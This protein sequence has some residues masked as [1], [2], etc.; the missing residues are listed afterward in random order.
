MLCQLQT[1]VVIVLTHGEKEL[2]VLVAEDL[3][4]QGTLLIY[5]MA[6]VS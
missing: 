2:R 4:V 1:L 6:I 3:H 5:F